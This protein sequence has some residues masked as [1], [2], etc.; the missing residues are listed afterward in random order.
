M[1]PQVFFDEGVSNPTYHTVLKLA[2]FS[3]IRNKGGRNKNIAHG[4]WLRINTINTKG[5]R[6]H[7]W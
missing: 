2:L 3:H 4:Q 6:D 5:V 7:N 1:S